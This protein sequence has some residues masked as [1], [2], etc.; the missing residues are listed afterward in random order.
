MPKTINRAVSRTTRK[1]WFLLGFVVWE[2]FKDRFAGWANSEIDKSTMPIM[3]TLRE[4]VH[5]LS[6][7][8][9][10]YTIAVAIIVIIIIFILAYLTDAKHSQCSEQETNRSGTTLEVPPSG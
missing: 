10:G 5:E 7:A 4:F 3:V 1:A 8:P 9:L 6:V 2:I